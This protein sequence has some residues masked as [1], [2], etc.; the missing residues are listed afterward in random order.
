M[1]SCCVSP[2]VSPALSTNAS[3]FFLLSNPLH[4]INSL[5]ADDVQD[6]FEDEDNAD[7]RSSVLT[8]RTV[9]PA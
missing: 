3:D 7:S 4:L 1:V 9:H 2:R 6:G 5:Q 8:V